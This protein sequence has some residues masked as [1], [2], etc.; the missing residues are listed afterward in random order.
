MSLP[1][2]IYFIL[3]ANESI[4]FLSGSGYEPAVAAMQI[5]LPT[6]LLIG[7]SNVTG[8]QVLTPLGM[9]RYVLISVIVG[10]MVDL[11]LNTLFIPGYGS[12]GAAFGT[13][14]AELAVL[15]VQIVF[16]RHMIQEKIFDYHQIL[17]IGLS[18]ILPIFTILLIKSWSL[19]VFWRLLCSAVLYFGI[20]FLLSL[21]LNVH[22]IKDYT[23]TILKKLHLIH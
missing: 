10:A 19:G 8:I 13:L 16:I 9:E 15:I 5:I 2:T 11:I 21:L 3:M 1:L 7:L 18:A 4:L 14:M 22:I 20:Y 6:I 17:R 12:A 23:L